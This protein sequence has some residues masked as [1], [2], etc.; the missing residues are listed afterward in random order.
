MRARSVVMSDRFLQEN[1]LSRGGAAF[2]EF[3]MGV[4]RCEDEDR[5]DRCVLKQFVKVFNGL[6][7][8]IG[9]GEGFAAGCAGSVAGGDLDHGRQIPEALEVRLVGHAEADEADTMGLGD[10][11]NG[12]A[13]TRRV[14]WAALSTVDER[15]SQS[16]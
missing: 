3:Q 8:R 16:P 13:G 4:R 6:Q 10:L 15:E 5:V 9:L 14:W 2:D 12:H 1:V 11:G 7:V